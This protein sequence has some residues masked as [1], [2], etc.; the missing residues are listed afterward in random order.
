MGTVLSLVGW[1][2]V[3]GFAGGW[4]VMTLWDMRKDA[5]E[6]EA[7]LNA[8][9]DRIEENNKLTKAALDAVIKEGK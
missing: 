5:Q 7:W 6:D 2:F 3:T 1:T 4:F 9:R 8:V